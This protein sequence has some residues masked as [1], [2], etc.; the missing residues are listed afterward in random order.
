MSRLVH[1]FLEVFLD[2]EYV[3]VKYTC[4]INLTYSLMSSSV[5]S[6]PE[7]VGYVYCC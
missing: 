1:S 7:G 4:N 6:S 3:M 2:G 5:H